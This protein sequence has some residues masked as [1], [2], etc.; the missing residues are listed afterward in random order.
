M[1]SVFAGPAVAL[2]LLLS[3]AVEAHHDVPVEQHYCNSWEAKNEGIACPRRMFVRGFEVRISP[4]IDQNY[5]PADIG[6]VLSNFSAQLGFMMDEEAARWGHG[7]PREAI[8]LLKAADVRFYI[9]DPSLPDPMGEER[10]W[11][12]RGR[13]EGSCYAPSFKRVS[14]NALSLIRRQ[15]HGYVVMHELAH[16]YDSVAIG[17]GGD[18]CIAEAYWS[19]VAQGKYVDVPLDYRR[20]GKPAHMGY[21][22]KEGLSIPNPREYW[23]AAV[24]DYYWKTHTYPFDRHDLFEH[25][26]QA[27][28]IVK[29]FMENPD[30]VCPTP[31]WETAQ[32]GELSGANRDLPEAARRQI[33][34]T[35]LSSHTVAIHSRN[36]LSW[37]RKMNT[38]KCGFRHNSEAIG[39]K[40]GLYRF[41]ELQG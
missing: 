4:L 11:P 33:C 12:C 9:G 1:K 27:Y 39:Q 3:T 25:D 22:I 13:S 5:D 38:T 30:A 15:Y 31:T 18:Q 10:W 26:P 35:T 29:T 40:F 36:S 2:A 19:A 37:E 20:A 6:K 23:A 7:W 32:R 28:W 16:A 14:I 21:G 41:R 17:D 34:V 24:T 8:D